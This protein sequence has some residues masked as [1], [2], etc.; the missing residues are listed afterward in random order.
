MTT[1]GQFTVSATAGIQAAAAQ[2]AATTQSDPQAS[3]MVPALRQGIVIS[4]DGGTPPTCTVTFDGVTNVAG[5]Q[6][7]EA[8]FPTVADL[9]VCVIIGGSTWILGD[10]A[11][12]PRNP[13]QADVSTTEAT[14]NAAYTNLPTIG[15]VASVYLKNNQSALVIVSASIWAAVSGSFAFAG[16][17]VTGVETVG[18]TDDDAAYLKLPANT[19]SDTM[20]TKQSV[21]TAAV[22]G[23][24]I[25]TMKYKSNGSAGAQF[26]Q[27]RIVVFP[28]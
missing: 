2:I 26:G 3:G 9:V 6:Y 20:V 5:I 24:H 4:S 12:W 17:A 10:L 16:Y 15:P 23:W 19:L 7:L 1:V 11:A 14:T 28:F 27:R 13:A 21:F 18:A 22:P 8:Y 25:F